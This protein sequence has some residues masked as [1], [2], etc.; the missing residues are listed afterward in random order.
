MHEVN[1]VVNNANFRIWRWADGYLQDVGMLVGTDTKSDLIL[2]NHNL[3]WW[4]HSN[5]F[6]S[7]ADRRRQHN[8]D[9]SPLVFTPDARRKGE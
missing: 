5:R 6:F 2:E 1:T 7:M 8:R 9:N 3:P 4:C